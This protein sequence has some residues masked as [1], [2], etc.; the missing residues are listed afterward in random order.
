MT[1]GSAT[2]PAVEPT[3][4]TTHASEPS[5]E[6]R[7]EARTLKGFSDHLPES[8]ARREWIMATLRKVFSGWGDM[9]LETP[10]LEYA[11]VLLGRYGAEDEKLIYR[12]PDMGGR[13]VAL[14]YDQTVPFA[15]V[16]AQY[17]DLRE[18]FYGRQAYDFGETALIRMGERLANVKPDAAVALMRMNV[19]LHPGSVQSYISLAYALTRARDYQGAIEALHQALQL[20]PTNGVAKGMLAQLEQ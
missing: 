4:P 8:A 15:R 3:A 20:E 2:G 7:I 14:R 19:D 13:D 17:R 5:R 9:P 10:A 12:F 1:A 16:I 6:P 18:R 11:D